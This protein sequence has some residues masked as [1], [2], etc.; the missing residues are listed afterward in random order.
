[1]STTVTHHPGLEPQKVH[2][3]LQAEVWEA[4]AEILL[5]RIGVEPGWKCLDLACGPTG[6]L[7]ILARRVG[8]EGL[9]LGVDRG[10]S[11]ARVARTSA[12]EAGQHQVHVV[13]ADVLDRSLADSSFDLVHLRFALHLVDPESAVSRMMR[14]VK[15]G[16]F[17]ALQEPDLASWRYHPETRA[18][19]RLMAALEGAIADSGDPNIGRRAPDL[20]EA[21]GVEDVTVRC[22]A[23]T[24]GERHPHMRLPLAWV[25][26][27]R[28]LI[29]DLGLATA[30]E[31]DGWVEEL[32]VYLDDA[33]VTM[34]TPTTIQAWGRRPVNS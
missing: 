9:V 28:D 2:Q 34:V 4:E 10:E 21:A 8:A 26:T 5:D 25:A 11:L 16:G 30:R 6:I 14:L 27:Q 13:V 33:A 17:V 1:V 22:A 3:S 7:S 23:L 20:L 31:L 19:R 12:V 18:W 29:L 15:P 32:E 24:L